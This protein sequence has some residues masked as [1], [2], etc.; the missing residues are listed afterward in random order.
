MGGLS[1]Y[2]DCSRC[3]SELH[4]S[5]VRRESDYS[6]DP[7]ST[8]TKQECPTLWRIYEY[9]TEDG[10]NDILSTRNNKQNLKLGQGGEGYIADDEWCYNCGSRGHWGDVSGLLLMS[11]NVFI[12]NV[13]I[14]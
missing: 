4:K 11:F 8:K 14:L 13:L 2:D 7:T 5:N 10:K 6:I 9:L 12:L 3:G 1:R